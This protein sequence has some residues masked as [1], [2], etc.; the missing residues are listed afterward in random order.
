MAVVR[1]VSDRRAYAVDAPVSDDRAGLT[2]PRGWCAANLGWPI[3]NL[4][5]MAQRFLTNEPF[6]SSPLMI[7]SVQSQP[8][9][10][11]GVI[12]RTVF[13]ITRCSDC[14]SI[15]L[16][17]VSLMVLQFVLPISMPARQRSS[18]RLS[19]G[20][21]CASSSSSSASTTPS[22]RARLHALHRSDPCHVRYDTIRASASLTF[23]TRLTSSDSSVTSRSASLVNTCQTLARPSSG[24]SPPP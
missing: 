20:A 4:A 8:G 23:A 10:D 6:A 15:F 11:Q 21:T 16:M 2:S 17:G 19:H 14:H 5:Q 9:S 1:G 12:K 13:C 18:T 22:R 3:A 24:T 7:P